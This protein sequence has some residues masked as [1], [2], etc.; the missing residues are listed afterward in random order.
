MANALTPII[1][2]KDQYTLVASNVR[3]VR[4]WRMNSSATYLFTFVAKNADPPTDSSIGVP[5]FRDK[6]PDFEDLEFDNYID[7]YIYTQTTD[8]RITAHAGSGQNA[9][10]GPSGSIKIPLDL[11]FTQANDV[12]TT[13]LAVAVIDSRQFQVTDP[14]S[15]SIGDII[16]VG[17]VGVGYAGK[18]LAVVG[19]LINTDTLIN[20]AFQPGDFAQSR[21]R[22]MNVDGS[23]TPQ[24][25]EAF[26][27]AFLPNATIN[28]SN[29]IMSCLTATAVDLSKFG[30][31]V[32]GLTYGIMLRGIPDPLKGIPQTNSWNVKTN[33]ELSNLAGTGDME[34]FDAQNQ[35]QG[36]HGFTWR[37]TYGGKEKHDTIPGM[38]GLDKIEIIIQDSLLTLQSLEILYRGNAER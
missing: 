14:S 37:Y 17:Q 21:T 4:L 19:D 30:D 24:I 33:R 7:V 13:L 8:G 25:F 31:I 26:V 18:V 16:V 2:T 28:M 32:S 5:I 20:F 6:E 34:I 1:T 10:A 11:F 38:E 36:Q 27:P 15:F 22:E 29:I 3:A 23:V 12:P 9:A 35:I